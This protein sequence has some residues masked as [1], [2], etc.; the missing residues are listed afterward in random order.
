MAARAA[1]AGDFDYTV[2]GVEADATGTITLRAVRGS[3]DGS[4]TVAKAIG[5]ISGPARIVG[6][7][8]GQDRFRGVV[9]APTGLYPIEFR[10]NGKGL[11]GRIAVGA[12]P[13]R[14]VS[15]KAVR[16]GVDARTP[17]R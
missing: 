9:A 4:M 14:T 11:D 1:L 12:I 17:R 10:V 6:H 7:V 5:G 16:R 15:F 2:D 3:L 13:G 8:A